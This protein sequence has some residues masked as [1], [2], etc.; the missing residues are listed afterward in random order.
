V[1][2]GAANREVL[3]NAT[4][5]FLEQRLEQLQQLHS[6]GEGL[7]GGTAAAPLSWPPATQLNGHQWSTSY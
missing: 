7:A 6:K 2:L 3:A 4:N 1:L 5:T